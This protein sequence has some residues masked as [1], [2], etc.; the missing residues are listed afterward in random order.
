LL[1]EVAFCFVVPL[2]TVPIST[3]IP[4]ISCRHDWVHHGISTGYILA[5][6]R[7]VIIEDLGC[8]SV[9]NYSAIAIVLTWVPQLIISFVGFIFACKLTEFC[10]GRCLTPIFT[11]RS[12]TQPY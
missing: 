11:R 8:Q 5:P 1:F 2:I 10:A 4:L 3:L 6:V 9:L 12:S 7:Y